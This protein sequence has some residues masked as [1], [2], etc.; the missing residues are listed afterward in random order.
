M[1]IFVLGDIHG[2][3]KALIQCFDRSGF[4]RDNDTLISLGDIT[5]GWSQAVECVEELMAIKNLIS[6]KG[7]HDFWLLEWLAYGTSPWLW[8]NKGGQVTI[9]SYITHKKQ[10]DSGHL[11]FFQKQLSYYADS[12]DR[13]F[14]HAGY[15]DLRGLGYEDDSVYSWDRL[16]WRWAENCP[17]SKKDIPCCKKYSEIFIGH[18]NTQK[19]HPGLKPVN[20]LNIWNLDQG[21]GWSGKLTM[22]DIDT[23]EYVQSDLVKTLYPNEKGRG[24]S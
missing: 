2:C 21:A 15:L 11:R 5:D 4:D 7:N 6:I 8:R 14:V 23:K 12:K 20:K 16:M 22:M 18:S 24:K 13:A 19:K 10:N 17:H 3:Y 1:R 9:D